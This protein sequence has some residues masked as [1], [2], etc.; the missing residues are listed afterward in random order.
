MKAIKQTH[1]KAAF[2]LLMM[3][4]LVTAS[5]K[6]QTLSAIEVTDVAP[7]RNGLT[8]YFQVGLS[9]IYNATEIETSQKGHRKLSRNAP[10]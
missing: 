3:T 8:D 4:F 2:R 7:H 10:L 9:R 6:S 5:L 1:E